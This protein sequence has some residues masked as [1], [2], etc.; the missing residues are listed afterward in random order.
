MKVLFI[1]LGCDKNL[2]DSEYMLSKLDK[3]GHVIVDNEYDAEIVVINTCAFICDAKEESINNILEMAELKKQ[4]K[5]KHIIVAGCL[6]E[7]FKD[8]MLKEIPEIDAMIGTTAVDKICEAIENVVDS[9][10][11]N[12]FF[13]PL[14]TK[15]EYEE[16]GRFVTTGG[17]FAYLKIAEGCDKCCTYCIIPSLRGKY[18]SVPMERLLSD[19]KE[20]V[21]NGV[22]ELILV[23]Q[24]TTVYGK[25]LYGKKSLP[26][27]LDE[28]N[29]IPDLKWI[30]LLYAY[31]EEIDLEL[32]N[33]IKRNEKVLHYID[34]PIQHINDTVLK[35]MGRRTTGSH[36][37]D[38]I[39]LLREHIPDICIRTSLI[40][41]F[42]GETEKMHE[43]L[44]SF[45]N[46]A[47]FDRLGCFTFSPEE[48]TAA[49]N[50]PDQIDEE[51]K[52][53]RQAEIMELQQEI[54]YEINERLVGSI[55]TAFVEGYIP[56][57]DIYIARTFK[58]A[59]GVDGQLFIN[60]DK[61]LNSGDFVSVKITAAA[62]YDLIGE[63][64]ESS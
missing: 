51:V 57:E 45:I 19:A 16:I 48:G 28:L 5:I 60:S 42:P 34:M 37:A 63:L 20:L 58:D 21:K 61:A 9:S 53:Q 22:S 43:E 6:S 1:S 15:A 59:P 39:E 64:Y 25:D 2:C 29:K 41:G 18:R 30:R 40:T 11:N 35:L 13:M 44:L 62:E 52:K 26:V 24:E 10:G 49:V 54:S 7:R 27:L 32:I 55:M 46:W 4:G 3:A 8:E 17:H 36:I 47:E 56:E 14:D 38:I 50:L 12:K 33:A 23:A 31:P